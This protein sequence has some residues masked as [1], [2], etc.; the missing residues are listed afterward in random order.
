MTNQEAPGTVYVQGGGY[1]P[2]PGGYG[3][4]PGG[5]YGQPM[6]PGGYGPP[7]GAPMPGGAPMGPPGGGPPPAPGGGSMHPELQKSLDTWFI[8]SIVSILCGC[9]C[10]AAVPIYLTYAG[11]KS[12]TEGNVGDAESK[13]KIAKICVI[14]GL[15]GY[16]L[17]LVL[18]VVWFV[19]LGGMDMFNR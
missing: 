7:P 2:P 14:L 18:Y 15:V 12:L 5:G 13:L 8:I 6:P 17:S 1:G 9:G 3:P 16:V 11:K 4:P 19:F 10:L